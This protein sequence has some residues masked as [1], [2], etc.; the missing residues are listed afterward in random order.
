MLYLHRKVDDFLEKWFLDQNK[1]PLIIKGPRQV[2]KTESVFHFA[3]KHYA[4]IIYIN[5]VEE[6]KYKHIVENGYSPTEIIKLITLIDNTKQF[7]P[8]KTLIFFDELQAFPE[9]I[10]SLKFFE[11]DERF[12]VICSGSLLG[13]HY[14]NIES[15]SVGYKTDYEMYSLDFEEFLWAKGYREE[16]IDNMLYH[17]KEL[18]PFSHIEMETYFSL[19][20]DYC[21]T[22]GMPAIVKMYIETNTFSNVLTLQNQII[23]DY[24]ED[25]RKY[26]L[27]LDQSRILNVFNHIP[28]QLSKDNKKF[29]ISKVSKDARFR[30]YRGCIDWLYDAGMINICYCLN[31]PELPL[32]G[33]YDESKFKIY[34]KDTGLLISLLDEESQLDLKLNKNLGVYK[35]ALYENIVAEGLIKSGYELYY[36][37][38]SDSTLEEDFFIRSTNCLIPIEVKSGNNKSKSMRTLIDDQRYPDIQYGIKFARANIGYVDSIYTFPLFL[39]F[40]LY[41]YMH[42]YNYI[43]EESE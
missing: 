43:I 28:V 23:L 15:H 14:K 19:F 41:R 7:I 40:L 3:N 35:G 22:G 13:I 11:I 29:Q 31:Y 37:K 39:V 30:D 6:P 25:M 18:I 42:E 21:I 8:N 27:G 9:I 34:L 20:M 4:S 36:Y 5:F 2:G 33:N 12:D 24:K 32:R 16:T 17:M 1:N 26:A 38:K 10:T